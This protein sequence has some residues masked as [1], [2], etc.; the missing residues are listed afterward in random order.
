MFASDHSGKSPTSLK[1]LTP[2]YLR[3]IPECPHCHRDSYSS[4]YRTVGKE[5]YVHCS[6]GHPGLKQGQPTYNSQSRL[7]P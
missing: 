5:Y 4:T 6:G 2:S 7:M 3:A 1:E